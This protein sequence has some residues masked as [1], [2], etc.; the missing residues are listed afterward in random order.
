MGPLRDTPNRNYDPPK[1][2][3]PDRW[4]SGLAAWDA[5]KLQSDEFVVDVSSWLGDSERLDSGCQLDRRSY[6]IVDKTSDIALKVQRSSFADDAE[7]IQP[8]EIAEIETL[9]RLKLVSTGSDNVEFDPQD[10]GTGISQVIPVIVASLLDKKQLV[11]IEQ[12]ELHVHPRIQAELG[13]LFIDAWQKKQ[14]QFVLET[15]SE[16]LVLRLQRRVRENLI[17]QDDIGVY[18]VSQ[19]E[20]GQTRVSQLRLDEEGDFIDNWPGGFFPERLKEI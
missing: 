11:A 9:T 10:V 18:Y 16:H 8:S 13:D 15:H 14:N 3:V 1:T 19:A 17:S 7:P 12:P 4:A 6:Y 20:D 2:K 5:L